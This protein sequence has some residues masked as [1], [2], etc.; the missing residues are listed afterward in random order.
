MKKHVLS[1]L[2]LP[3]G[4]FLLFS[5][6]QSPA[7]P[8][9]TAALEAEN[10]SLSNQIDA[11]NEKIMSLS[12]EV[13]NYNQLQVSNGIT[14]SNL[15]KDLQ[16]QLSSKESSVKELENAIKVTFV[17]DVFFDEGSDVIK[18]EGKKDLDRIVNTLLNLKDKIIRVEGYT[19]DIPIAPV[20]QSKFASNWELSTAR[21]DAVVRYLIG[22]GVKPEVI[23]AA[24]YSK[25][26]PVASNATPEG[27]SQNRRI[28]I[29]LVPLDTR[30]IFK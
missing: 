6:A 27:R 11:L 10:Q 21:A 14:Y 17:S 1:L 30:S 4:L 2:L 9:K 23:K 13:S 7:K 28:E 5:C 19:D 8:D 29:E 25:F 12:A 22:K 15:V 18:P 20:H 3:V 16:D 26:N 24:G